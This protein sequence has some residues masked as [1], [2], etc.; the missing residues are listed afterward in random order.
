[1]KIDKF[2]LTPIQ[3]FGNWKSASDLPVLTEKRTSTSIPINIKVI[4]KIN[5]EC[6]KKEFISYIQNKIKSNDV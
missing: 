2:Y 1:M 5:L 6:E 4:T 3:I